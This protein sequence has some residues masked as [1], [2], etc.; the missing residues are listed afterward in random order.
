MGRKRLKITLNDEDINDILEMNR[1]GYGVKY[2]SS[3][4]GCSRVTVYRVFEANNVTDHKDTVRAWTPEKEELLITRYQSGVEIYKIA[5]ELGRTKDSIYDRI[6]K[7][8]ADGRLPKK[9]KGQRAELA[10]NRLYKIPPGTRF[11]RLTVI[12]DR[13]EGKTSRTL[14]RYDCGTELV[15]HRI[16]LMHGQTKSCGCLRRDLMGKA[17]PRVFVEY[18][19]KK[20]SIRELSELTGIKGSTLYSRL[21]TMPVENL[22]APLTKRTGR[23]KKNTTTS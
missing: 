19:G 6:S 15:V 9:P 10:A 4:I 17:Y 18:Q 5:R 21:R 8:R 20:R 16:R 7:L 12:E 2:I 13:Y 3:Y 14:V 11:T 1:R 22:F 23:C